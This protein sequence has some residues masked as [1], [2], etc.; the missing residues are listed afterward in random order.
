MAMAV[1]DRRAH[2][3]QPDPALHVLEVLDAI[4]TCGTDGGH[5]TMDSTCQR[6]APL[7]PQADAELAELMPSPYPL[8]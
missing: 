1:R 8:P 2:R 6:P 7:D 5:V 3:T 4:V